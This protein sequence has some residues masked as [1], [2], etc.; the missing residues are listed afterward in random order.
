MYQWQC[1][2]LFTTQVDLAKHIRAPYEGVKHSYLI[3]GK[4]FT[5][6]GYLAKHKR[7]A[8]EGV[9]HPCRQSGKQFLIFFCQ[10][11]FTMRK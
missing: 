7:V 2:K 9:R 3:C 10:K 6:Q 5:D 8:H 4:K 1:G 11:I